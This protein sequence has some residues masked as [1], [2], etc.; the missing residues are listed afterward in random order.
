MTALDSYFPFDAGNG[1]NITEDQWRK[2][3]RFWLPT[4]PISDEDNELEVFADSTGMQVKVRTGKAWIRGHYGESTAEKTL[5]VAAADGSNDRIDRAVL[6]ADFTANTITLVVLEGTPA[7]TPAAPSLM[8]SAS[9]WEISLAQVA[10]GTS[11]STIDAGDVTD[12]RTLIAVFA[13]PLEADGGEVRQ[14]KAVGEQVKTIAV[15]NTGAALSIDVSAAN[16]HTATV[17]QACTVNATGF[18]A[19]PDVGW[20]ELVLTMGSL[21]AVTFDASWE[22]M[23]SDGLPPEMAA[24]T[25]TSILVQSD[26]AGVS[27]RAFFCGQRSTV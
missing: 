24:S 3:A 4:G 18:P 2:M 16:R 13:F 25:E 22:W 8:Q 15:G 19:A 14:A 26:A 23:T 17:S 7:T 9:R 1:A 20:A 5:S 10:V 27:K 11:V 6:R 12:E 21:F